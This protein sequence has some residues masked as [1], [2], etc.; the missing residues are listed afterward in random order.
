VPLAENGEVHNLNLASILAGTAVSSRSNSSRGGA[1]TPPPASPR[2]G[3]SPAPNPKTLT[4]TLTL[5]LTPTPTPTLTPTLT[6]TL[7]RRR[8]LARPAVVHAPQAAAHRAGQALGAALLELDAP[9][10]EAHRGRRQRQAAR[11]RA[12]IAL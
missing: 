4:L 12:V 3:V 6:L 5:T 7:T 10:H 1:R 9:H 11:D 2:G 8:C